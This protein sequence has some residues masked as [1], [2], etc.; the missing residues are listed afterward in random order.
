MTR[1]MRV[2]AVDRGHLNNDAK[3]V[4]HVLK[5]CKN[6]FSCPL[7]DGA[8]T[9]LAIQRAKIDVLKDVDVGV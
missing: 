1:S 8:K 5:R 6:L 4:G 9:L 3:A 7:L 2:E